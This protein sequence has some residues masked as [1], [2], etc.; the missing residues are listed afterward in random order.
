MKKKDYYNCEDIHL[1]ILSLS[2][3]KHEQAFL[4][5]KAGNCGGKAPL[6]IFEKTALPLALDD[7]MHNNNIGCGIDTNLIG[8]ET[9]EAKCGE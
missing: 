5:T 7:T 4:S 2:I 8:P 6:E 1:Y 3:I 9:E